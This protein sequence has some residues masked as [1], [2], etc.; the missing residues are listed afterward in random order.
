MSIDLE[1]S[2]PAAA[3]WPLPPGVKTFAVN[4]YPMAY[5][6]HGA[7]V[8]IVLVHGT[9]G[10]YRSWAPQMEAL[11]ARSTACPVASV[12]TQML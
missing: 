12:R 3:P 8:P 7:G 2:A 10:D 9:N 4:G 5:V 6:E 1:H 11:G